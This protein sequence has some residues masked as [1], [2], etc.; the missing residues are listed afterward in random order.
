MRGRGDLLVCLS[1][2]RVGARMWVCARVHTCRKKF[3]VGYEEDMKEM[4][5]SCKEMGVLFSENG[6]ESENVEEENGY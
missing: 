5:E 6:P 2:W 4:G 3:G 1:V